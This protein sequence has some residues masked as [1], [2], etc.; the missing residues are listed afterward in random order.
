[1]A[2]VREVVML[3]CDECGCDCEA[4][5]HHAH[6]PGKCLVINCECQGE[7]WLGDYNSVPPKKT[8][9]VLAR[10]KFVGRGKP[11]KQ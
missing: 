9:K 8:H 4:C 1:M 5:Y 10:Y 3:E 11:L 2:R 6:K 7:D